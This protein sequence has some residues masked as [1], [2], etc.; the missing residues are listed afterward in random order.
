MSSAHLSHSLPFAAKASKEQVLR[1]LN[2]F[3]SYIFPGIS[4]HFESLVLFLPIQ[5]V[6]CELQPA[7]TKIENTLLGI[8][9]SQVS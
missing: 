4:P 9:G 5:H 6:C 1:A 8:L 2:H 7:C 3:F